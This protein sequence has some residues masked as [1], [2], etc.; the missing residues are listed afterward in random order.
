M[1]HTAKKCARLAAQKAYMLALEGVE[2]LVLTPPDRQFFFRQ[3]HL[4]VDDAGRVVLVA[5]CEDEIAIARAHP[6]LAKLARTLRAKD[7][8][9]GIDLVLAPSPPAPWRRRRT[10][11]PPSRRAGR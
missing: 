7:L 3:R 1:Q 8:A 6:A 11:S 5:G 4:E 2:A 10:R 9:A